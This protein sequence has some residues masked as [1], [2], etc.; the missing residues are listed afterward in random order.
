MSVGAQGRPP[1]A[2]WFGQPA[3]LSVLAATEMWEVF[4]FVGMKTLLVYYMTQDLQMPQQQASLV[5]GFYGGAAYF[6]PILGGLVCGRWLTRR[7]A[8]TAGGVIMAL[9]H[10]MLTF[11][12]LFFP[13][14][15]TVALGAGLYLPAL[16]SQ[17]GAL[18]APTDARRQSAY[19]VYYLGMNLGA[20]LAPLACGTVGELLGWHYGFALAGVGMLA[21]VA[22]YAWGGRHL[23][24]EPPLA[25][26][27]VAAAPREGATRQG[28][29]LI[30]AIALLVVL[31]RAAYEQIGNTLA[32]WLESGVDRRIGAF[33]IPMTWF[34]SLN[35]LFVFLLTPIFVARWLR[36][37]AVGRE[38]A[39]V[40]KMSHGAAMLCAGYAL[41]A[42]AAAAGGASTHWGWFA[43]FVVAMTAGELY[44]MPICLALFGRLAPPHWATM[45][46]AIWFATAFGANI[47]GGVLGSQ[48][49]SSTP[50][51]FFLGMAALA[52]AA[53]LLL[54]ILDGPTR[55]TEARLAGSGDIQEKTHA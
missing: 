17:I 27:R 43:L 8:V 1:S 40:R 16:P 55:R 24:P 36:L 45:A 30:G 13:A 51:L 6:T 42:G 7:Q 2:T 15:A 14:L 33:E 37:G 32:L 49:S 23:P 50:P 10:F 11:P 28:F 18:F 26:S 53:S 38:P 20:L 25:R 21:G 29:V 12:P 22:I 48:W 41:L 46:A 39:P 31:F 52:L 34:Q 4:S 54:A 44:V 5:Y 3:G 19:S 9:G 47:L 35:P